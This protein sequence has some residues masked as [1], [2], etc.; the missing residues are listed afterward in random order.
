V[1][2][3]NSYEKNEKGEV[4]PAKNGKGAVVRD[5]ARVLPGTFK[6]ELFRPLFRNTGT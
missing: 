4:G 5:S 1:L 3:K 6:F 2:S